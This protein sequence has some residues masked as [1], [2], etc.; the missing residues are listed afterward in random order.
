MWWQN[1]YRWIHDQLR[2]AALS[3]TGKRRESFQLDIG[4]TLYYGLDKKEVQDELPY[5]PLWILSILGIPWKFCRIR[6]SEL[7][8]ALQLSAFQSA[9][10]YA[11]HGIDLLTKDKW[12]TNR[13]LT[14]KLYIMATESEF[15][16]GKISAADRYAREVWSQDD[17]HT[18]MEI[19][20][21]KVVKANTI[22]S[23]DLR[24]DE[25]TA[26][27]IYSDPKRGWDVDWHGPRG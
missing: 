7:E 6:L 1:K 12:T 5:S 19:L 22:G 25:G 20:P 4:R 24:F 18:I 2:E 17:L 26:K 15:L 21:L 16:S 11:A 13:S 3:L 10:M 14:L 8:K 27:Y 9:A 23:I